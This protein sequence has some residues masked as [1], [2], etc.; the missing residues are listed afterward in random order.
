MR[1]R[2]SLTPRQ[3]SSAE[4]RGALTDA[5]NSYRGLWRTYARVGY[6]APFNTAEHLLPSGTCS[7]LLASAEGGRAKPCPQP[8]PGRQAGTIA[9]LGVAVA[10]SQ[11]EAHIYTPAHA[12]TRPRS[13]LDHSGAFA[14]QVV[15]RLRSSLTVTAEMG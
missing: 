4:P 8:A 7:A 13:A 6:A 11:H 1:T 14:G 10:L 2:V 15:M 3:R 9:A 5:E 12:T